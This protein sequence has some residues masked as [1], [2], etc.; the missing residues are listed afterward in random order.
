MESGGEA[1]AWNWTGPNGF[2]SSLQNPS[3]PTVMSIN[4]GIYYVNGYSISGCSSLDSV[5]VDIQPSPTV[6]ILGSSNICYGDSITIA[7]D[8]ADNYIW[9]TT[10]TTPSILISPITTTTYSVTGSNGI[11]TG[12]AS[13][14]V[15]VLPSPI[16][17]IS[18]DSIIC[19]VHQLY[20][21]QQEEYHII[22]APEKIQA[23]FQ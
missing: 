4:A 22:G 18:G 1:T 16:A 21:Q 13:F 10:E 9:N 7:G 20:Y 2:S 8:G 3:I 15:T 11:C 12:T 14:T 5:F 23:L 19:P 6:N 17:V